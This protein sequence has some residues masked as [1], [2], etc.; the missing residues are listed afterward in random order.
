MADRSFFPLSGI[1]RDRVVLA[2][3][4]TTDASTGNPALSSLVGVGQDTVLSMTRSATGTI[5]VLL[6]TKNRYY[7]VASVRASVRGTAGE[8]AQVAVANEGSASTGI[9]FTITTGKET[10]GTWAAADLASKIIDVHAVL[11]NTKTGI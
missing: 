8:T 3:N 5:V 2:F 10:T 9:Q 6:T 4:F 11:V 7:K 1:G